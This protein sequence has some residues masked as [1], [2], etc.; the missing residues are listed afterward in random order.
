METLRPM[1]EQQDEEAACEFPEV[2]AGEFRFS[3]PKQIEEMKRRKTGTP[4]ERE[5]VKLGNGMELV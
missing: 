2:A 3:C 5:R 1:S 4:E